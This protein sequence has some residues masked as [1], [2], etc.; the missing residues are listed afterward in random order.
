MQEII[1]NYLKAHLI[2]K[3]LCNDDKE[4]LLIFCFYLGDNFQKFLEEQT[5]ISLRI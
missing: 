1:K 3:N 4:I 2:S 5:K